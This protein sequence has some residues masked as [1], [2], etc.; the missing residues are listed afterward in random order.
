MIKLF[1]LLLITFSALFGSEESPIYVQLETEAKLLPIYSVSIA[2]DHSGFSR[3]YLTQLEQVLEF[4]LSHNGMT[5]LVDDTSRNKAL[6]AELSFDKPTDLTPWLKERV[7][8]V[9]QARVKERK[10]GAALHIVNNNSKKLI[11]GLALTGDFSKDRRTIHSLSDAI[12]KAL[13]Q[14]DG[15]A[16]TRIL[17]TVKT[18]GDGKKKGVSEVYESDYDGGNPRQI[19]KN[20]SYAVT[21]C[22][23]PP[24]AGRASR[25]F[26]YVSYEIGQPKI[27]VGDLETGK[28]QRL[29]LLKGNQLMPAISSQRDKIAFISDVTGNPDL[30]LQQFDPETGL[31][32]KPRQLY[33]TH[34][35][36]QGTPTFSPDGSQVAFVS[37]KDGSPKIY[38]IDI[39]PPDTPLKEIKARLITKINRENSAPCWSP[40]GKKIAYCASTKGVRQIWTYDFETNREHQL[41]QGPGN[42]ENPSFAPNS[43]HLVFNSTGTSGS[44]LY[45]VNLNQPESAK[46][47]S[48]KGEKHF[49]S[50][51][52]R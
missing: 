50:W 10:L 32:N 7:Y 14:T 43:L 19:T 22:Y 47:S 23:I 9:V 15:I 48:G 11:D 45:I 13:F 3:E 5:Y 18:G 1:S 52:P 37:N 6:A 35:A 27:Y 36:T 49:P 24:R 40:D 38:V 34:K 8:F 12:H 33:A 44:D 25:N 39:P 20:G 2:D 16:T 41:T 29:S 26:L 51:E 46:I 21:P 42:K 17:Y 28:A 4:D 30:F 31:I